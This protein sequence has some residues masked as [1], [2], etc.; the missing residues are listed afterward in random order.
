MNLESAVTLFKNAEA[1][2]DAIISTVN[3][4][5]PTVGFFGC[6]NKCDMIIVYL[7]GLITY[8]VPLADGEYCSTCFPTSGSGHTRETDAGAMP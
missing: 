7:S 5:A 6:A 8:N 4:Y 1:V 2:T 3:I